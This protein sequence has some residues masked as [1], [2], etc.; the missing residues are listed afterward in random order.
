MKQR[1]AFAVATIFVVATFLASAGAED[2]QEH[3]KKLETERAAA[4]VKGDADWLDKHTADDYMLISMSGQISDKAKMLEGFKSGQSKLTSD[5]LSDMKV[6]VYGNTA[7]VTG[8]ADVKGM[9]GGQDATGQI[10]FTR[11]YVKKNGTWQTVSL[12]QT[13]IP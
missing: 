3:L 12:Q 4:V 11:V 7:I 9:L 10:L 13:R 5:D 1:K 6:R 8:K 2:V